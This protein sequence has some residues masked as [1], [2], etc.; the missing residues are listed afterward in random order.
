MSLAA[1]SGERPDAL[2]RRVAGPGGTT[3]AGLKMLDEGG[4]LSSLV[5]K[6]LDASHRRGREMAGAAREAGA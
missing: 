3:E 4:A 2:A 1:A 5:L 6:T